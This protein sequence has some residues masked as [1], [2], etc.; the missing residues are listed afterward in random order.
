LTVATAKADE[1][2]QRYLGKAVAAL[3]SPGYS[4]TASKQLEDSQ[5][6]WEAYRDKYCETVAES[7][8]SGSLRGHAAVACVLRVTRQRTYELW[9]DFLRPANLPEPEKP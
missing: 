4:T 1:G 3:S 8:G 7:F 9:R 2:L 5:A 6:A